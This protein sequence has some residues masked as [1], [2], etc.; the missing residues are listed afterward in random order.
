V[1][2]ESA[3]NVSKDVIENLDHISGKLVAMGTRNH[4]PHEWRW[5]F[6]CG[7]NIHRLKD[8]L[9]GGRFKIKPKPIGQRLDRGT[10]FST[11]SSYR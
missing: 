7:E 9:Q 1:V 4:T 2:A 10:L 8:G 5:S 6:G 11:T 3:E